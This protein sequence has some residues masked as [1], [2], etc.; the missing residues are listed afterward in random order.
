[1]ERERGRGKGR[2]KTREE[3]QSRSDDLGQETGVAKMAELYRGRGG[4][5]EGAQS[6]A[7]AGDFQIRGGVCQPGGS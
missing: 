1:M 4:D 6:S 5:V 7:W 3:P 2:G